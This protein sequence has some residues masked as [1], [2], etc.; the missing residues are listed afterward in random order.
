MAMTQDYPRPA[1]FRLSAAVFA[2]RE[3]KIL[4]LKRAGGELTGAWYFPGGGVDEGEGPEE[5]AVRELREEAGIAPTGPLHLVAATPMHVYGHDSVQLVYLCEA[6]KGDVVLSAEHS[7]FR[8]VD[9]WEYRDSYFGPD[10]MQRVTEGDPRRAAI[11]QGVR[12]ALDRCIAW[13][14]RDAELAR[15]RGSRE[16]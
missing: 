12:E 13:L 6:A 7:G 15:L 10:E 5:A 16:G 2:V 1:L 9:P 3:G 8:W 4:I 14:D 11:V